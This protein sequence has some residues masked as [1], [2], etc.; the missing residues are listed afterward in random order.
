MRS[1]ANG[2]SAIEHIFTVDVEEYFQVSA[3]DAA[4][5]RADWL[6]LPS[7]IERNVDCLLDLLARHDTSGTFFVLGWIADMHPHVVQR[8]ATAGH[9]VASHGWWHRRVSTLTPRVFQSEVRSSKAVLEDVTGR[10]VTGFRAPNFSI[11]PGKEWAFDV[12][13]EEGYRYDSS[14]FPIRRPGYG[15]PNATPRPHVIRRPTGNLLEFPLAT[16]A[17]KGLRLPGAGGGYFR[18]LPYALTRAAFRQHAACGVP[19]TFYIHSWEF[20]SEQPR[21]SVP[22]LT[23]LRHYRGLSVTLPR[24]EQLLS[25]FRFTSVARRLQGTSTEP[26]LPPR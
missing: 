13:L 16:T 22:W 11:V 24:L 4:V 5:S 3:F 26:L 7:R 9:E 17:W 15:Y 18:Q 2:Q 10:E 19:G 14:L 20:D 6:D 25:E 8:I 1:E 23:R 12:L 21:V